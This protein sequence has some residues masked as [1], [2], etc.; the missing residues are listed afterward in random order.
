MRRG[1]D[2]LKSGLANPPLEAVRDQVTVSPLTRPSPF[3]SRLGPRGLRGLRRN[4]Q[5]PT[6]PELSQK[7]AC[8][9]SLKYTDNGRA[10]MRWMSM[11]AS[12]TGQWR[13]F[14]D[15]IPAHWVSEISTVAEQASDDWRDFAEQL[16]SRRD[17][18]V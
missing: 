11:H 18:A 5:R 4:G 6:W 10:F 3:Q 8:D 12:H 9:P 15:S 16:K 14:V 7:L 13:D 1:L 17:K 2:P